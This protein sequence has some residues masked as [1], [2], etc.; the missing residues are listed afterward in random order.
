VFRWTKELAL[1]GDLRLTTFLFDIKNL[2]STKKSKRKESE[3]KFLEK[4]QPRRNAVLNAYI[5]Q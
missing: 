1:I 2:R 3:L 4:N 5:K